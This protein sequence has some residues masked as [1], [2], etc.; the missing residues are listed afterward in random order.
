M[1]ATDAPRRIANKGVS[2]PLPS[3]YISEVSTFRKRCFRW[4][5]GLYVH[6]WNQREEKVQ[7][8]AIPLKRQ[9]SGKLHLKTEAALKIVSEV[10]GAQFIQ[11][12]HGTT[13]LRLEEVCSPSFQGKSLRQG[14]RGTRI[15][16]CKKPE[17]S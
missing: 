8:L 16:V 7:D 17:D 10:Y 11:K 1:L 9:M 13:A 6:C 4:W 2:D 5:Y 3:S 15:F 14:E 12:T